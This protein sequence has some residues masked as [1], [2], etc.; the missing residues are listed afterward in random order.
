MWAD[1]NNYT[2][3]KQFPKSVNTVSIGK[4][5]YELNIYSRFSVHGRTFTIAINNVIH[6]MC[7]YLFGILILGVIF[8]NT[9]PVFILFSYK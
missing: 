8:S 2:T 4:K 5:K 9:C 6:L 3:T 7:L 1:I